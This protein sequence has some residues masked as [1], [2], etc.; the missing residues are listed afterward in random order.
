[1]STEKDD[2][3]INSENTEQTTKE[4]NITNSEILSD[5]EKPKITKKLSEFEINDL[6]N[7]ND[8][9][10]EE[11]KTLKSQ[12]VS[13]NDKI[14]EQ[15]IVINNNKLNYD[16][17]SKTI[18]EKYEKEIK[19]LKEKLDNTTN[20]TKSIENSYKIKIYEIENEKQL[21]HMNNQNLENQI[22][23]LNSKITQINKEYESQLK[24]LNDT[25]KRTI[26]DYEKQ[27][28]ELKIKLE[29]I[30]SKSIETESKLKTQ[31]QLVEFAK[32][33]QEEIKI[34]YENEIKELT[35]KFNALKKK[36][37][38]DKKKKKTQ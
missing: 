25:K 31:E 27:I 30:Q 24:I 33:D 35:N 29:N 17:E 5:K 16:K 9:L 19:G 13:L 10:K 38:K 1:M 22:K 23:D 37:E 3:T 28:D 2:T 14:N 7:K 11:V 32:L 20:E 34:K 21:L 6:I 36:A 26:T 12:I 18:K 4:V 8:K 15:I